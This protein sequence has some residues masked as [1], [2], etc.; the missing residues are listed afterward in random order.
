MTF[1]LAVFGDIHGNVAALDAALAAVE[2][3]RP[4]AVAVTGDLV[5]NGPRP[6]EV[7][8]RIRAL[9]QAGAC[10]VQGNTDI[11][12]ADLDLSAAFPWLEEVPAAQRAAAEW[13]HDTLAP[14]DLDLLRRLPAERR[15]RVGE[16]LIL[17]CH[18]SPGSQTEGLSV[19]LDAAVTV[20]RITRT[21]ARVIV[22]G[23]THVA[24]TREFGRRLICNPGSCGYSFDGDADAAW[25]L[26]TFE[27][28][29]AIVADL[30]RASYD[31][32]PMAEEVAARGLPG[33][34]YRAATIRTGRF[35]R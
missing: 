27:P 7:L 35:V 22:C 29:G 2:R 23:H 8:A 34:V 24:E 4:D 28:D 9:E 26:V 1:R 11:A 17:I 30:R 5:M 13:A 18:G 33:D 10:V 15:L 21:D 31:P 14:A 16:D 20:Q 6:A 19:G 25:A 32:L 12:V 3:A